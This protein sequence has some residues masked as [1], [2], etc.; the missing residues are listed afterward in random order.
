MDGEQGHSGITENLNR[1]T[2]Q[3]Y[4]KHKGTV[5]NSLPIFFW[6]V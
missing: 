1:L 6:E 4:L 3:V 5:K 2:Q